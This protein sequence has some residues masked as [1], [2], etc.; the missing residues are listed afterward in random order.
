MTPP[1]RS[2]H[3]ENFKAIRDSG[4]I[5][6]GWLSVLIGNNGAGKSGLLEALEAAPSGV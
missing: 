6:F 1:L 4:R 2:F 3:A 5:A